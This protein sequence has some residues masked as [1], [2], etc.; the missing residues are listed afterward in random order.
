MQALSEITARMCALSQLLFLFGACAGLLL[1]GTQAAD[2]LDND[3]M[4]IGSEDARELAD[5]EAP[6]M[7]EELINSCR[8]KII[9]LFRI[10]A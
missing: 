10:S 5:E 1:S 8:S 6:N 9:L 2:L 4:E 3:I 7:S